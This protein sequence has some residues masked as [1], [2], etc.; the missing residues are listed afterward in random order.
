[1]RLQQ[2]TR[3][4]RLFKRPALYQYRVIVVQNYSLECRIGME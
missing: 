3:V 2:L 1:M 4:A